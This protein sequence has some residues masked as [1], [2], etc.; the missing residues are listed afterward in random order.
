MITL[1]EKKECDEYFYLK[2]RKEP[3]RS[4]R[5]FFDYLNEDNFEKTN[6]ILLK[7]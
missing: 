6:L 2:H 4:R 5:Y 1:N 7:I 3:K